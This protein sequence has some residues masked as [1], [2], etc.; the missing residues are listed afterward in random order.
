MGEA[1]R[2]EE[3]GLQRI[4]E[5]LDLDRFP[6]QDLDNPVTRDLIAYCRAE[7]DDDGCCSVPGFLRTVSVDR[8]SAE[9]HAL[10]PRAHRAAED[11]NPYFSPDDDAFPTDHPRR[12]FQTR[13]NGFVCYDLIPES[14]DL[15]A[16]YDWKP[17]TAF[18]AKAFDIVPLHRYADPLAAMPF[19]TM[20]P[21]DRFPWHFD[22]NEFT[23]TLMIQPAAHGGRFEYVPNVRSPE[24]ECYDAV[25]AV[26][27]GRSDAV[28]SFDLRA[29]DMQL[30]LGRYTLHRVTEVGGTQ[31]RHVAIP[32]WARQPNMIGTR[33]R[34]EYI[35]G[36]LSDAHRAAPDPAR[37]DTLTD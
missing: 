34:T 32:S 1:L 15:R 29:G 5:I 20:R 14:S 3:S 4:A 17:F 2:V 28:R 24:D 6:V 11:H 33:H 10:A 37:A 23:V 7:L 22:T 12:R 26:M 31:D 18:L 30:F 16:L 8:I 19:N 27:D 35:Y 25:Q 9:A 21:G 36:R 13:T